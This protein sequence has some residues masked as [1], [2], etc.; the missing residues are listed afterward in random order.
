MPRVSIG[1]PVYNGENYLNECITSVLS[2]TYE[3]FELIIS[4]NASTDNT[5]AICGEYKAI[6][7][8]IRYH[9]NS[10]NF[11]YAKNFNTVFELS[12]G[13][14]FK[15]ISHDDLMHPKF[16]E[17]C[18]GLLDECPDL[19][20]I[21]PG[22]AYIDFKGNVVKK[23][24]DDFSLLTEHY[25]GRLHDLMNFEC[26]G[27]DIYWAIYGLV[28]SDI[29]KRTSLH[30][31]Y[32]AADRVLLLELALLGKMKSINDV[33]LY[34]RI[35]PESS[36]NKYRSPM[37]RYRWVNSKGTYTYVFPAWN[38]C[39]QHYKAV[40]KYK[41]SLT[42]RLRA[43]WEITTK[44]IRTDIRTLCGEARV[45]IFDLIRN[46]YRNIG[47]QNNCEKSC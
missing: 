36:M 15:W 8:R 35:H 31:S 22:L 25:L 29:L 30:G 23:C 17:V 28:R 38:V 21:Y 7:K 9:R 43:Y 46:R 37:Q 12:T 16:L 10:E 40:S 6:D 4:D 24:K 2:Q 5:R 20:V 41:M 11:G 19:G 18:V 1:L 33:L 32:V 34:I 47:K 3:D 14:Y 44:I 13:D 42:E 27:T 39:Y 45:V 26:K